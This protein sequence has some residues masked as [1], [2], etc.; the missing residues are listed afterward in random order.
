MKTS[1]QTFRGYIKKSLSEKEMD[2]ASKD[3]FKHKGPFL[4]LLEVL[5]VEKLK[6]T[7]HTDT[8]NEYRK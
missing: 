4:S 6:A 1:S 7:K 2:E 3:F 8:K 5:K